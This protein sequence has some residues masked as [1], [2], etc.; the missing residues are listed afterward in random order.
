M[1]YT[2]TGRCKNCGEIQSIPI[3]K[4][5]TKTEFDIKNTKCK[6]CDVKALYFI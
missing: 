2:Q 5:T 3:P 1:S 4:G 6:H